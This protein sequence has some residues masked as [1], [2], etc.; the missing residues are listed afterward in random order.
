MDDN[1]MIGVG[2]ALYIHDPHVTSRS[3]QMVSINS[4]TNVDP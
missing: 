3:R 4:A 1:P 2:P